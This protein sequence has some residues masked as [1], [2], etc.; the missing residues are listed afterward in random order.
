[1]RTE[2]AVTGASGIW[3]TFAAVLVLYAILG[4]ATVLTLQAL[5]RRWRAAD[6]VEEGG[7]P[8]GPRPSVPAAAVPEEP[9]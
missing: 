8:Y 2:D 4:V 1:M 9:R 6:E 5:A 7:L 3:V